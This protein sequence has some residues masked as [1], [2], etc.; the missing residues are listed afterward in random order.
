MKK[1]A[2]TGASAY[3]VDAPKGECAG[4]E[5]MVSANKR[6]PARH[7]QALVHVAPKTAAPSVERAGWWPFA[8]RQVTAIYGLTPLRRDHQKLSVAIRN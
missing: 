7:A 1:G 5:Q 8:A 6:T 2:V 4:G 3:C